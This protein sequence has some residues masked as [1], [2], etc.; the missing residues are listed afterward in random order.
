MNACGPMPS[1]GCSQAWSAAH[2]PATAAPTARAVST[3]RS[4]TSLKLS[5]SCSA[6]R[7]SSTGTRAAATSSTVIASPQDLQR[8]HRLAA[9]RGALLHG[10]GRAGRQRE[11]ECREQAEAHVDLAAG[12]QQLPP[13]G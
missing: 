9:V 2:A 5:I 1:A 11:V 6:A 7:N 13:Q 3:A 10:H 12:A 4:G 8:D